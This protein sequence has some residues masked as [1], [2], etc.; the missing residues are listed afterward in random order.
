MELQIQCRTSVILD[1]CP[2]LNL[3]L[4]NHCLIN[5]FN[6]SLDEIKDNIER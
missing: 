5:R 1:N 6:L 3:N 4:A 2:R